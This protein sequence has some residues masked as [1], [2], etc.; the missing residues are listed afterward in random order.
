[1]VEDFHQQMRARES[2]PRIDTAL[3]LVEQYRIMQGRVPFPLVVPTDLVGLDGFIES[4]PFGPLAA[5]I[6]LC[7][8]GKRGTAGPTTVGGTFHQTIRFDR[9]ISPN[10]SPQPVD[11]GGYIGEI[12]EY[13]PRGGVVRCV[14]VIWA[15]DQ[16]DCWLDLGNMDYDAALRIARSVRPLSAWPPDPPAAR[17]G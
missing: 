13:V 8:L 16:V 1:M 5:P 12:A 6:I 10:L 14:R 2:Q 15:V 7:Y 17:P 4:Y 3:T 11:I 9:H